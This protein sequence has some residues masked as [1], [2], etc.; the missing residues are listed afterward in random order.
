MPIKVFGGQGDVLVAIS[1]SG[2]SINILNG[3]EVALQKDMVV[4]TLS[5][6]TV[7]NQLRALGDINFYVPSRCYG[8]VES[9]HSVILHC[10]L[11]LTCEDRHK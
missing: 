10:I 1:S 5:G 4:V 7:D 11:D 2:N 8:Y 9:S 3:V 6:F